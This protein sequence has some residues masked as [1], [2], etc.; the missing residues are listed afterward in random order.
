LD[1]KEDGLAQ[2]RLNRSRE[3]LIMGVLAVLEG[4]TL[5]AAIGM[6]LIVLG[7]GTFIWGQWAWDKHTKAGRVL[8]LLLAACLVSA[9]LMFLGL[10]HYLER[11][12][13]I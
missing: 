8:L 1:Y 4:Q 5:S 13:G 6:C 12:W 10:V 7:G 3:I 9:G 11:E 2:R